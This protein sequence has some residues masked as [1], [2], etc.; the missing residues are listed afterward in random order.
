MQ[1]LL[2]PERIQGPRTV[3]RPWAQAATFRTFRGVRQKAN[4]LSD[5]FTLQEQRLKSRFCL[6]LG[7]IPRNSGARLIARTRVTAVNHRHARPEPAAPQSIHRSS[8]CFYVRFLPRLA[9]CLWVANECGGGRIF[10]PAALDFQ[11]C[12][13]PDPPASFRPRNDPPTKAALV[14]KR[15]NW[16]NR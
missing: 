8:H 14:T 9:Y 15:A 4:T 16:S 11:T 3:N 6:S 1:P 12:P 7:S 10:L 5:T 2:A 13:P